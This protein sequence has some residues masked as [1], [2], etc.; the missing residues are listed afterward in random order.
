MSM[1]GR[2]AICSRGIVGL[3]ESDD[4][5]EVH[6]P[7]G[8]TGMAYVGT[9]LLPKEF[10]GKPWSSRYPIFIAV[11]ENGRYRNHNEFDLCKEMEEDVKA[12]DAQPLIAGPRCKHGLPVGMWCEECHWD[13][14]GLQQKL[15]F[16][17]PSNDQLL[18]LADQYPAPQEWYDE[19]T[20]SR[21][22]Q[23]NSNPETVREV[24]SIRDSASEGNRGVQAG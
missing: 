20:Q 11:P 22:V 23:Q 8:T 3:V 4:R 5:Q 15:L 17:I 1:K 24:E 9:C 16:D 2:I 13:S 6:Y 12:L 19:D 18:Q 7:D 14:Q 21:I 10:A